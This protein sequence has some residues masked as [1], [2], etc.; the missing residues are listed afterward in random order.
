MAFSDRSPYP[1]I[2]G[3][4]LGYSG[5]KNIVIL[6]ETPV[7]ALWL[8][9][10]VERLPKEKFESTLI[11][12]GQSKQERREAQTWFGNFRDS[13]GEFKETTKILGFKTAGGG[14]L[15][16]LAKANFSGDI[17]VLS[18]SRSDKLRKEAY[19]AQLVGPVGESLHFTPGDEVDGIHPTSLFMVASRQTLGRGSTWAARYLSLLRYDTV[20]G[21]TAIFEI[22]DAACFSLIV[23]DKMQ[24]FRKSDTNQAKA[25]LNYLKKQARRPL[26]ALLSGTP[27]T[28]GLADLT[29]PFALIKG[30]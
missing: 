3:P 27:M 28:D 17:G 18:C 16:D 4:W 24:F 21:G 22:S 13:K 1:P 7:A 12:G 30:L 6:A 25:V 29:F 8:K 15:R 14:D 20:D 11:H 9:V 23:I 26:V 10:F 5:P 19:F 2:E